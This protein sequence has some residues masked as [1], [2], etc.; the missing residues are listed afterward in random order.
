MH[1]AVVPIILGRGVQL[2]DGLEGLE[3]NYES[4]TTSSPE[5]SRT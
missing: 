4:E 1:I 5:E 2:W 3:K